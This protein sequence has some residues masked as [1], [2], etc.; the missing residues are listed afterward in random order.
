MSNHHMKSVTSLFLAFFYGFC[1]AG[2]VIEPISV[3]EWSEPTNGLRA[4]LLFAEDPKEFG[5]RMGVIYLEFQNVSMGVTKSIFYPSEPLTFELRDSVGK[6]KPSG[7]VFFDGPA[8]DPEWL[9]LPLDSTLRFRVT[10][11]GFGIPKDGGLFIGGASMQC[12]VIIPSETN[13]CHLS[14]MLKV[15]APKDAAPYSPWA[16]TLKLPPVK[17]PVKSP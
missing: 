13:D 11:S 17:I 12:W 2:S 3:G 14:G 9:V 1:F 15:T 6:I 16:G 7:G 5:T 8:K 10:R 4:R